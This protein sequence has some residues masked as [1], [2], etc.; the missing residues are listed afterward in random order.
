MR[1]RGVFC[2]FRPLILRERS[3]EG[4]YEIL[5][6]FGLQDEPPVVNIKKHLEGSIK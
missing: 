5:Q 3:D 6:P 2:V 1:G 4:S